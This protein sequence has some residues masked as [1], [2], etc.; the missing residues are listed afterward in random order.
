M[1]SKD[2]KKACLVVYRSVFLFVIN[3]FFSFNFSLGAGKKL[4]QREHEEK[5]VPQKIL[6]GLR[7]TLIS[8]AFLLS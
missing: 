2:G 6:R 8:T 4:H 7:L 3:P 1:G 5:R